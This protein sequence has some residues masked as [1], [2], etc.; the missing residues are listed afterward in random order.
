MA[1][2]P[3]WETSISRSTL[4]EGYEGRLLVEGAELG[5]GWEV[6]A[7]RLRGG[8]G[9]Q[10]GEGTVGDDV[11]VHTHLRVLCDGLVS[12][13][14]K[15]HTDLLGGC[16]VGR[17]DHHQRGEHILRSLILPSQSICTTYL[18]HK[19][20]KRNKHIRQIIVDDDV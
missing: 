16:G 4:R 17:L 1:T 6:D 11:V 7:E 9:S 8:E 15:L 18:L 19:R 10:G 20:R 3:H 5:V 12:A 13:L 2:L 14:R